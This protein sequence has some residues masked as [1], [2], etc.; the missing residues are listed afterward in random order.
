MN[1]YKLIIKMLVVTAN[2]IENVAELASPA[3]ISAGS[4]TV[5]PLSKEPATLLISSYLSPTISFV[6]KFYY[7]HC[8]ASTRIT[9]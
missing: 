9:K 5:A 8:N 7:V 3:I 4:I 2:V 6:I 1:G